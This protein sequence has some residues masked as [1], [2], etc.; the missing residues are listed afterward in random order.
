VGRPLKIIA[1]VKPLR[2]QAVFST[3]ESMENLGGTVREALGYGRQR[4][5]RRQYLV[6]EYNASF[7]PRVQITAFVGQKH[8]AWL[9]EQS[10]D[11]RAPER[12]ATARSWRC[13]VWR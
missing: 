11:R 5:R 8:A 1:L 7:L 2:V 9:S 4:N 3:L 12:S 6:S 10:W 13:R